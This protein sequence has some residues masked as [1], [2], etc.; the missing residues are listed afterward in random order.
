MKSCDYEARIV[1]KTIKNRTEEMNMATFGK[2]NVKVNDRVM[3]RQVREDVRTI[4]ALDSE[5]H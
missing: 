3:D 5:H 4:D 2:F 1:L